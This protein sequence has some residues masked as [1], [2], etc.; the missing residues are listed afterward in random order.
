MTK[1]VRKRCASEPYQRGAIPHRLRNWPLTRCFE[2]GNNRT[3]TC[4]P[5]FVRQ[6]L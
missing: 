2:G 5:L 6:V 4:D 1:G 3:R